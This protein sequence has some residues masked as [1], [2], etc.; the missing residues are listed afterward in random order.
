MMHAYSWKGG[1]KKERNETMAIDVL[2]IKETIITAK[3]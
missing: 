1:L 2:V 3:R